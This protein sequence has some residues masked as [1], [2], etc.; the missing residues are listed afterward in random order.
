[1]EYSS[2]ILIILCGILPIFFKRTW[3]IRLLSLTVLGV[4]IV[5]YMTGLQTSARLA[6]VK[7]YHETQKKPSKEWMDGARKTG[8]AVKEYL[9]T[10]ILLFAALMLL[11]A[12]PVK[13]KQKQPSVENLQ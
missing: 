11:A 9:P 1:M 2:Y 8:I 13:E 10:G 4:L 3:W 5:S 7:E 6:S 12:R